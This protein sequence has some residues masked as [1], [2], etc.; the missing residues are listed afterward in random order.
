MIKL[1][2]FQYHTRWYHRCSLW[3]Y[4]TDVTT[5]SIPH[6]VLPSLLPVGVSH[7]CPLH[8]HSFNTIASTR[9]WPSTPVAG[10]L[11]VGTI[12]SMAVVAELPFY[13]VPGSS[14]PRAFELTATYQ[15]PGSYMS[16]NIV[17]VW[18]ITS[19]NCGSW[20]HE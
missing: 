10:T 7:R 9:G 14:K 1:L 19:L 18:Y 15:V 5:H 16:L 8:P 13:F 2:H 12:S 20:D 4:H 11:V 3:A 6:T 17:H